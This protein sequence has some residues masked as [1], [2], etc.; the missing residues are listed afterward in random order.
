MSRAFP[1]ATDPCLGH[2]PWSTLKYP[3]QQPRPYSHLVSFLAASL[4]SSAPPTFA[5][6][7]YNPYNV[8]TIPQSYI[9]LCY[10]MS[11]NCFRFLEPSVFIML[12]LFN[13]FRALYPKET[14][15]D[16]LSE[17]SI[18]LKP[19]A[20]LFT[21]LLKAKYTHKITGLS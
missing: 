10:A 13:S 7:F 8:Y 1:C 9:T 19:V 11:A 3:I 5:F 4:V 6:D 2:P 18:P 14:F 12:Y 16:Q 20:L 21:I 15:R 17:T